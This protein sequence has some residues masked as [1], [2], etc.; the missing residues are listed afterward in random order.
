MHLSSVW[1]PAED[2]V[3]F[4]TTQQKLRISLAPR[5]G[6]NSPERKKK[7]PTEAVYLTGWILKKK[8]MSRTLLKKLTLCGSQ[9]LSGVMWQNGGPTFG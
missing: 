5:N 9:E 7:K 1:I 2:P 3:V 4:S 8:R 6:Q